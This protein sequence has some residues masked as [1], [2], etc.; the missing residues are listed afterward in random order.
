MVRTAE[1]T[2]ENGCGNVPRLIKKA[3]CSFSYITWVSAST[4]WWRPS[5]CLS[6]RR[7][8]WMMIRYPEGSISNCTKSGKEKDMKVIFSGN[9]N[10]FCSFLRCQFFSIVNNTVVSNHIPM[11]LS[12][13]S[14][15]DQLFVDTFLNLLLPH[16][17]NVDKV[18]HR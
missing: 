10:D 16:V 14:I 13:N 6:I 3:K 8:W 4:R 17:T 18:G 2:C 15:F 7:Q 5:D 9:Y 12:K 11:C 1:N